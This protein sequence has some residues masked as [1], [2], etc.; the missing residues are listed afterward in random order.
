MAVRA[1]TRSR[2]GAAGGAGTPAFTPA[3]LG[4][5]LLQWQQTNKVGGVLDTAT[6]TDQLTDFSQY[7]RHWTQSGAARPVWDSVAKT[8]IFNGTSHYMFHTDPYMY[9]AA[10]TITLFFVARVA[11]QANQRVWISES[12]STASDSGIQNTYQPFRQ[13][14]SGGAVT[15]NQSEAWSE[16]FAD[17]IFSTLFTNAS[18]ATIWTGTGAESSIYTFKDTKTALSLRKDGVAASADVAYA[19]SGKTQVVNRNTIG[20]K[21]QTGAAPAEFAAMEFEAFIAVLDCTDEER[22]NME[23]YLQ[24]QYGVEL[25][26]ASIQNQTFQARKTVAL[27]DG[28]GFNFPH[29]LGSD[30]RSLR[31]AIP[32]WYQTNIA[33]VDLGNNI[34]IET[35][36]INNGT[37]T[38]PVNFSGSRTATLVN[39]T[40]MLVS[41]PIPASAFSLSKFSRGET[42]WCKGKVGFTAG[43]YMLDNCA[44]RVGDIANC[45]TFFYIK[46]STT[47]ST[48]DATGVYTFTGVTPSQEF[49][50]FNPWLGG[51]AMERVNTP[52]A[53]GNSILKD[54]GTTHGIYG[55]G[56]FQ[57]GMQSGSDSLPIPACNLSCGGANLILYTGFSKWQT[58]AAWANITIDNNGIN[59][60]LGGTPQATMESRFTTIWAACA[61]LG[62]TERISFGIMPV[63]S[64]TDSWATLVNQTK[65]AAVQAGQ[66]AET[67]NTY[68]QASVL[69]DKLTAYNSFP[70]CRAPS[71]FWLWLVDGTPNYATGDGL[72]TAE[73]GALA[74]GT[75]IRGEVN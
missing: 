7:G 71:D 69:N 28:F 53:I 56:P 49:W 10:G 6:A 22:D 65:S 60:I 33:E 62:H 58:P 41:D 75:D 35:I 74:C 9:N 70:S 39:G 36:A 63:T 55:R 54:G 51:Q 15:Q 72:H 64:S 46:A 45:Q 38:V 59:D 30:R 42:Y 26:F 21:I 34:S 12:S 73:A 11:G 52:C 25:S 4:A 40:A 2:G 44:A 1:R 19:R 8:V 43:E 31:V 24:A 13:G 57:L 67:I 48:T 18:P 50:A 17:I 20:C 23:N 5:R 66:L 3:S 61:A 47:V 68:K 32:A 14:G 27:A 37:T 16:S 29:I